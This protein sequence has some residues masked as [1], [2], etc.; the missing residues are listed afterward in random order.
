MTVFTIEI[1]IL[2]RLSHAKFVIFRSVPAII[3][4][5][6]FFSDRTANAGKDT[7]AI[8]RS[9]FTIEQ[10]QSGIQLRDHSRNGCTVDGRT[11]HNAAAPLS[12]ASVIAIGRYELRVRPFSSLVVKQTSPALVDISEI[13]L[14]AGQTVLL[15]TDGSNVRIVDHDPSVPAILVLTE[16][17]GFIHCRKGDDATKHPLTVN[18]KAIVEEEFKLALRDVLASPGARF[19]IHKS[20]RASIVCGNPECRLLNEPVF[21]NNCIWCGYHL[22]AGGGLSRIIRALPGETVR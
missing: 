5:N 17:S 12:P 8:S 21:E 19:E 4:R 18:K 20:D 6:D 1:E 3:G 7:K 10:R 22:A 11:I 16:S 14:S 15:T 9:H 13:A 2:D